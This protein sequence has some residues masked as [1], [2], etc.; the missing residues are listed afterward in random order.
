[1]NKQVKVSSPEQDT[2]DF[3][4]SRGMK[5][6][7]HPDIIRG[8]V[9]RALRQNTYETLE[10]N[11]AMRVVRETDVVMELGAGI[12]Y[13]S[14]LVAT[15][16]HVKSVHCFEANPN[17]IPYI[18]KVHELNGVKNAFV[19]NAI[20]GPRKG[21]V[22]FYIRK[23][24]LGSS[25][26]VLEEEEVPPPS[27]KVPV[28]NC[29]QVMKDIKPTI[30]ICDIEGAEADLIPKMDLSGLR[31]AIVELHPQWIG[32]KGVNAVFQAFMDAGL[33]Y[34]QRGSTNKVVTFRTN[35]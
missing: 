16:R 24:I 23:N 33:A 32:P 29:N 2:D 25:M 19:H 11:A 26:E 5:F 12:G 14:T 31:A 35:W 17:L 10:T 4:K 20:I 9:R 7:K 13:M 3:L 34:Y 30:L 21:K 18:E 6:P 1:M 22:D 15:K 27:T 8:N 28:L